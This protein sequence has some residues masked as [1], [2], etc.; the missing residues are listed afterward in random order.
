MRGKTVLVTGSTDGIGKQ[1]ALDLARLGARVIV[2]GRDQ[3]KVLSTVEEIRRKTG[4]VVE[5]VAADFSALAQVRRMAADVAE[6]YSRLDVLINNAGVFMPKQQLSQ[7]GFELTLAVNHLA[8]FLLTNLL[9]GLLRSSVPAR[10][11]NVSSTTHQSA[12]MDL[13]DLQGKRRYSGYS[14][15]GLSKLANILFTYELAQRLEAAQITVNALHPGV[16]QTKMLREG[17]PGI[18]GAGLEEGAETCV[19]LASSPEVEGVTG[20]YFI[21]KKSVPS[22]KETYNRQLQSRLW[23]ISA[24]WVGLDIPN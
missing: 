6:R 19:Y 18:H 1:S 15:Y 10:V 21:R 12:R 2:H 16:I 24:G 5:W 20:K 9:I 4:G 8:P 7:D 22:S 13:D 14:A 3:S 23:E 17:Y 11:V